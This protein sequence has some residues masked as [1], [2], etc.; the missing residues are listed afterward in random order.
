MKTCNENYSIKWDKLEIRIKH[1]KATEFR[2]MSAETIF[3]P[4]VV[5]INL[6]KSLEWKEVSM[7]T[8]LEDKLA[9]VRQTSQVYGCLIHGKCF[10]N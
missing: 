7:K 4:S 6:V 10:L 2:D 3:L 5:F 1:L 9:L 8:K